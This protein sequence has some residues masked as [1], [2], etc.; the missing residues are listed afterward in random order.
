MTGWIFRGLDFLRLLKKGMFGVVVS[1]SFAPTGDFDD[2]VVI[3][4]M[5]PSGAEQRDAGAFRSTLH[6]AVCCF[7]MIRNRFKSTSLLWIKERHS[8]NNV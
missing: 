4:L 8:S 1:W 3:L 6:M 5:S 7:N 2:A